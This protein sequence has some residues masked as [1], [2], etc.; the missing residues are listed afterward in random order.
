[1]VACGWTHIGYGRRH[2]RQPAVWTRRRRRRRGKAWCCCC[3][4]AP[5]ADVV[6]N[7]RGG[8]DAHRAD[9]VS[10]EQLFVCD[11]KES[12]IVLRLADL[13]VWQG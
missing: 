4:G 10:R 12:S 6:A 9:F 3:A 2:T 5:I 7:K 13:E 11:A 8:R 1:M